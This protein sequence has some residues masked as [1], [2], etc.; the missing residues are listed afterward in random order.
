MRDGSLS[1]GASWLSKGSGAAM[2]AAAMRAA[3]FIWMS[4]LWPEEACSSQCYWGLGLTVSSH[5][6]YAISDPIEQWIKVIPV[7]NPI[8]NEVT[9]VV[10]PLGAVSQE[11]AQVI[12]CRRPIHNEVTQVVAPFQPVPQEIAQVIT[13]RRSVEDEVT[14]VVAPFQPVPQ[15]IAQVITCR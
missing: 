8:Q 3:F 11:I 4:P 7:T 10:T 14:Q 2:N 9:Q 5:S 15:E 13:R 12:A 6:S 1:W